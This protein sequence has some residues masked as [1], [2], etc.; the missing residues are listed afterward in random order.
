MNVSE[1]NFM[2]QNESTIQE[3]MKAQQEISAESSL[4]PE[5]SQVIATEIIERLTEQKKNA[6]GGSNSRGVQTPKK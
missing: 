5:R 4:S 2:A 1:K 3:L 6:L